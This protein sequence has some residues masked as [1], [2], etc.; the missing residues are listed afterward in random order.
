PLLF[1]GQRNQ[2][3]G[4]SNDF[5]ILFTVG[6]N[7][8][9]DKYRQ[10]LKDVGYK[11][12]D[13][14]NI[15]NYLDKDYQALNKF[16]NYTKNTF[17]QWLVIDDFFNKEPI[18]HYDGDIV[19]NED[20]KV[21]AEKLAGTTFILQGCPAF[22]PISNHDWFKQ[23]RHHLNLFTQ[24]IEGYSRKAWEQRPGW[25]VTFRTRWAGSR[26][27]KVLIHDQ[28]LHSHLIHTGQLVQDNVEDIM[29]KL[30]DYVVFE[31]PL[32]IHLYDDNYPYTYKRERNIDYFLCFR[33]DGELCT[34]K[35]KV[36]FW[37][38]QNCFNFYASK[39]IL[40]QKLFKFLPLGRVNLNLQGGGLETKINKFARKYLKHTSR[41]NV[42]KY[43]FEQADFSGLLTEKKWWKSG[44]FK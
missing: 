10:S 20:P 3:L 21:I 2:R 6:Y 36:L 5:H 22:A 27:S 37:H 33:Q 39:Y 41:L 14:S 9:S 43:Y 30:Q 15:Y 24:D 1:V 34:Y 17:L 8:L 28:D 29:L 26:F 35:K 44:V 16:S 18:I 31:N 38:M 13:V 19:S 25:E 32:F 7:K 4:L 11:L 12:H 42:Y 23:Y 40:R